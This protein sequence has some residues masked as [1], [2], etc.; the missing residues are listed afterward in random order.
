[1]AHPVRPDSYIEMNNF[2]TVTVYHKGAE[3]VGMYRTLLGGKEAFRNGMDLYFE[4]HDGEAVT[5]DDFRQAMI[6][7]NGADFGEFERWYSQGGT[8]VVKVTEAYDPKEKTYTLRFSQQTKAAPG[9]ATNEPFM[10]PVRM[11]LLGE[12]GNTLICQG[13]FAPAGLT[14]CVLRFDQ[15]EQGFVFED[16]NERPVPSLFR[17]WSAPVKLEFAQSRNDLALLWSSDTDAFNRWEAGQRLG[18]EVLLDLV[19]AHRSGAEM[20]LDPVFVEAF[21][22]ILADPPADKALFAESLRLPTEAALTEAMAEADPHAIHAA[23]EFARRDLAHRFQAQLMQYYQGNDSGE[24][25]F[26]DAPSAA[27]RRL[28]GVCL[29][30]LSALDDDMARGRCL[31]QFR[32]ADNMTDRVAAL[33]ILNQLGGRERDEALDEF[34]AKYRDDALVMD[35][36]FTLQATACLEGTLEK[37]RGLLEHPAYDAANPNKIR[38]LVGAFGTSNP[39]CFHALDGS[40]HE[41]LA[42]QLLVIDKVNPSVAARV[43]APFTRFE[44]YVEPIRSSMKAQLQRVMDAGDLSKNLYEIVSKSLNA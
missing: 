11:G 2:Y 34:E 10:I 18:T 42:D 6:D 3:V 43:A 32:D 25:Y 5:C 17:E 20:K 39:V 16:V 30:Y 44:K 31:Q 37:T 22:G 24:P 7:A 12:S 23:R 38:A 35:K 27:R 26:F 36:W 14:E 8:P 40:G 28:R 41:F 15:R 9:Q 4:R 13:E 21:G 19:E 33:G 1:M 29:G